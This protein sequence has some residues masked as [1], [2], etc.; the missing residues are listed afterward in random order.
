MNELRKEYNKIQLTRYLRENKVN[1]YD[2]IMGLLD[3]DNSKTKIELVDKVV[4]GNNKEKAN[5]L[6]VSERTL[7]RMR[8]EI[9]VL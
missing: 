8:E 3:T 6:G 4:I 7:Y 2:I 5:F 9:K 1:V